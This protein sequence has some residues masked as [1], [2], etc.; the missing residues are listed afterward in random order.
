[1]P[2]D[3]TTNDNVPDVSSGKVAAAGALML[4]G[5]GDPYS[6]AKE[7]AWPLMD[8]WRELWRCGPVMRRIKKEKINYSNDYLARVL[9]DGGIIEADVIHG[10]LLMVDVKSFVAAGGYD[11]NIFLYS[12]ERVLAR[13]LKAAGFNT[14]LT[15]AVYSHGNSE[16]MKRNGLGLVWRERERLKSEK[17][18]Y[19][20]YLKTTKGQQAFTAL[21]QAVVMLETMVGS[22]FIR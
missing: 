20:T 4:S 2:D 16:T 3:D 21:Y 5:T 18:Y 13:R 6:E 8:F 17:Y 7:C 11:E 9:K 1:V 12:E 14:V 19:R 22:L 10:A 15:P